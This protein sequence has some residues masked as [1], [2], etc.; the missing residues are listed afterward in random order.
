MKILLFILLAFVAFTAC[1][2][3]VIMIGDPQG[4]ILNIPL[5]LLKTTP[6]KDFFIPGCILLVTGIIN[7]IAAYGVLLQKKYLFVW[8]FFAGIINCGWIIVQMIMI[9]ML[10]GIQF[11]YLGIG[12]AIMI[13]SFFLTRKEKASFHDTE[14]MPV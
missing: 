9:Q 2:C 7:S 3:G 8:S 5:F 14:N 12:I 13:L 4:H 6:F 10:F 1:I 11:L